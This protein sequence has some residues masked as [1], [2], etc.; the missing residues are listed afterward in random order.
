MR[1]FLAI[2]LSLALSLSLCTVALAADE[3]AEEVIE[4]AIL[5]QINGENKLE[6][7][8]VYSAPLAEDVVVTDP[9]ESGI[10]SLAALQAAL[11]VA[12]KPAVVHGVDKGERTLGMAVRA[13]LTLDGDG[14]IRAIELCSLY[15]RPTIGISW[16]SNTIGS[17]YQGF[18]EAFERNGAYA[19]YLPRVETIEQAQEVL[20]KIDGV[21]ETGGED[22]NPKLYDQTQSPHGSSGYNDPRDLSDLKLM[23]Q[24]IVLD[25][26]MLAVCRGEQGFNVAMGGALIQDIPYYLGQ[27]VINGEIAAS[28]VTGVVSGKIPETVAGYDELPEAIKAAVKDTGYTYYDETGTRIGSTYN[29]TTGEYAEYGQDCDGDGHLRVQIDG[30]IHSG[31]T[32][33]HVL[34]GGEGNDSIAIDKNSKWLYDIFGTETLEHVATAHHQAADP[35]QLG[36]GITVVARSSDGIVEALEYQDATFALFLQW[37]PERDALRDTRGVDVDQDLCNAPLQALV[38]Y[39]TIVNV[40][41]SAVFVGV[42]P[43]LGGAVNTVAFDVEVFALT[44]IGAAVIGMEY[45][46]GMTLTSVEGISGW[47]EGD[48]NLVINQ[49]I[50]DGEALTIRLTFAVDGAF[51]PMLKVFSRGAAGQDEVDYPG[52]EANF[53]WGALFGDANGDGKVAISDLVRLRNYIGMD[54]EGVDVGAGGDING[55]GVVNGIDLTQLN[56]FFAES[57]YSQ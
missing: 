25:I 38:W 2:L 24:A 27:K 11:G 26:P 17:D 5:Y 34:A 12:D 53:A 54:G 51:R 8:V 57:S 19:V 16:K 14:C 47:Q 44:D 56:R 21:F 18:A 42:V 32:G 30:L 6:Y 55:D 1:K 15:P 28:R 49:N 33:Y 43:A 52:G 29:R 23:Q 37:H 22:W 3:A 20:G 50:D 9:T 46:E 41:D 4:E 35:E 40:F 31:G 13:N 36:E 7:N 48:R 45:G 39:A 10:D